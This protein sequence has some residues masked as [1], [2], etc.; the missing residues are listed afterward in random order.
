MDIE[1]FETNG[2]GYVEDLNSCLTKI[3]D[4]FV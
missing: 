1:T 3:N 2:N 4:D